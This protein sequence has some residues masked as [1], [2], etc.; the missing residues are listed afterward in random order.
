MSAEDQVVSIFAGVNGYL[1]KMVTSEIP[2]FEVLFLEAIKTKHRNIYDT[3]KKEGKMD[4]V[5]K[6]LRA[7]LEEFIPN[8]WLQMKDK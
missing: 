1:D 3:L 8:C 2:K 6:E 5:E 4:N 7:V